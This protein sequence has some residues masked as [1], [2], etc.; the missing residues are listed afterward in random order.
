MKQFT[1]NGLNHAG[2]LAGWPP[3]VQ[4]AVNFPKLWR[5]QCKASRARSKY[6]LVCIPSL[7]RGSGIISQAFSDCDACARSPARSSWNLIRALF[8]GHV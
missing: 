4:I 8:L 3:T 7:R 5:F 1:G 6:V 2:T